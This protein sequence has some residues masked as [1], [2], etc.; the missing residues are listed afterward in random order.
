[1]VQVSLARYATAH[2]KRSS[3]FTYRVGLARYATAHVKRSSNFTWKMFVQ[4]QQTL[5][6]Q[7][8]LNKAKQTVVY[9]S[10]ALQAVMRRN[11]IRNRFCPR[12]RRHRTL[13]QR[14]RVRTKG[15]F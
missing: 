10:P 5:L 9:V 13:L 8:R 2:I 11:R 14:L 3:R 7:C 4:Q 12:L 6:D 1:M 15:R